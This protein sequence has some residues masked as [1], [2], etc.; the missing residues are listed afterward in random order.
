MAAFTARD[1]AEFD[2]IA[3]NLVVDPTMGFSTH[4]MNAKFRPV[5]N[6]VEE[7]R[8]IVDDYQKTH[9]IDDA[10]ARLFDGKWA[11]K[12]FVGKTENQI[13]AFREHVAR[14][15]R[16]F[17]PRAGF[18]IVPSRRYSQENHLGAK[19]IATRHWTKGDKMTMLAGVIATMTEEEERT[20]LKPGINDFSV[21]FST[22]KHCSQ[23][24][25]GPAAYINHDCF[26]TCS[27]IATD[28]DTACV[29]VLRNMEPG[30][31]VTCY[32]GSDF[33]GVKN[34]D[35]ECVTCE[36][37][38]TG[39]FKK[40][41]TGGNSGERKPH[42]SLRHT[43]KRLKRIKI[44]ST[45]DDASWLDALRDDERCRECDDGAEKKRKARRRKG[46]ID[47]APAERQQPPRLRFDPDI[48]D[49]EIEPATSRAI[50]VERKDS[51]PMLLLQ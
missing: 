32:Y 39:A 48:F 18:R 19:I 8:R 25:L 20:L 36:K 21:M 40:K 34:E 13:G 46:K 24:W 12:F 42:Y 43:E 22:R 31:E 49:A 35:C 2:D 38:K 27:F 47:C 45:D 15:L 16:M 17:N 3:V 7:L 11:S 33:F 23:L 50:D 9:R 28:R 26:P 4:K 37:R 44:D 5:R 14:Y 1:L 6:D 29:K 51:S 10:L 41:K 30:D